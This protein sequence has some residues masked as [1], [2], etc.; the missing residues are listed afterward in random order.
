MTIFRQYLCAFHLL[1]FILF[2]SLAVAQDDAATTLRVELTG[3]QQVDGDLRRDATPGG[4]IF[5]VGDHEVD[6]VALAPRGKV[7][8]H[9]LA[10]GFANQVAE[11][12]NAQGFHFNF[13]LRWTVP[14]SGAH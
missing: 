2:S 6:P 7:V 12:Q 14:P 11:K 1:F 13:A 5:A 10:A 4:R 3:L 9:R 8:D